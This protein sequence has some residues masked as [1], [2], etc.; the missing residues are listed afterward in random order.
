MDLYSSRMGEVEGSFI[1]EILKV[2]VNKDIISFAG[3]LPSP[4]SFPT[5]SIKSSACEVLDEDGDRVLQY[6]T[7][8]GYFPLREYI[9]NRYNSK[10]DLNVTPDDILITNG[11]QQGLDLIGKVF[12]DKGDNILIEKPGYLGAIQAFSLY[13][14]K[15]NAVTLE[16][17]GIKTKELEESINDLN[18][19]LFYSVPNFQNPT[20]LTYSEEN[21]K[22]VGQ[23][24][25]NKNII[26]VEDD[27]YGELRFLGE[28]KV[29]M[30]KYIG[31]KCILL[32]SFSK[33][34]SPSMRLG[35]ICCTDKDIMKNIVVAKQGS[36]LHTNYF[37][38]RVVHRYLVDNNLDTHIEKIKNIYKSQRNAM[39]SAVKKYF[40]GNVSYT[41][42][43]GGMFM[44]VT[45]PKGYSS[46]ELYEYALK[47]NVVFVP[48]D[49]FYKGIKGANTF[50]LNYTNCDNST[51][52]KGIKLLADAI[53]SYFSNK[54]I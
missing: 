35:W 48:G 11:S 3:G 33:I 31:D 10:Y 23:I 19:K 36:D 17:E 20:G 42:P 44:W 1:R 30:K 13:E 28:H 54:N 39:V 14:V 8:E 50:R 26:V 25:E 53:N 52:E 22:K 47:N 7:T 29:P 34:V 40:P 38:Q 46:V 18:P 5:E 6:S 27:P 41:E 32:G 49:C 24:V 37:S 43:E 12:L 45:L 9:A 16:E 15:F 2:T 51:I 21:R 4:V